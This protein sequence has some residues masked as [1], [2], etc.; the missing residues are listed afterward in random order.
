MVVGVYIDCMDMNEY[1]VGQ[2]L[3]NSISMERSV[4]MGIG[5]RFKSKLQ[6]YFRYISGQFPVG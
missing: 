5:S 4:L 3:D 1:Y 2:L 6:F